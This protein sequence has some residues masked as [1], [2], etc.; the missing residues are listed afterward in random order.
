M[1]SAFFYTLNEKVMAYTADGKMHPVDRT[2]DALG[3]QAGRRSFLEPTDRFIIARKG[4]PRHR[5]VVWKPVVGQ[6]PD[7]PSERIIIK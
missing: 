7:S 5:S 4:N 6:S 2:L 1:R 3:E